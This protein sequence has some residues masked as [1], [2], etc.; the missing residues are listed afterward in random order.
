MAASPDR[1]R[2][3]RGS[4]ERPVN[5][6]LYRGT[7][8]LVGL[9]LLL[10]AFS[11]SRPGVLPQSQLP[12]AF[13]AAT[14]TDLAG[15]L[16]RDYPDRS[17]G[18]AGASNAARWVREQLGSF[19]LDVSDDAFDAKIPGRGT[20]RLHNLTAVV[21]G[22]SPAIVVMAH[23]DDDGSGAGANE[24]ASG[25]AA[26]IELARLY[27][28]PTAVG[29]GGAP[30]TT[31]HRIVF[32]STDGGAFGGIG[33]AR[34]LDRS[35]YRDSVA[36]T[37]NLD[38]VAGHAKPRLEIAGDEPR[39]PAASL[40]G[41]AAQRLR[42]QTSELPERVSA[43]GQL[44][45]L[46]FPFT[47]YEQGPFVARG[48]PAVTITTAGSR[49][50]TAF[51]DRPEALDQQTLGAI[52]T[53]SQQLL[54][55]LDQGLELAQGT[56]TYVYLGERIVRGWTIELV[57]FAVLLPFVVTAV[58]LYARCRRR[59]LALTAAARA[60]RSRLAFWLFA[61]GLFWVF[62]QLGAFPG[63][64]P[65]PPNPSSVDWPVASLAILGV[66]LLLAWLVPRDRLVP[67][68]P[69]TQEEELAG[70]TAALLGLVVV[71]LLVA[72][73]NP[74][75]L[76]FVLPSLHAWLWLPQLHGRSP[77][78][79]FLVFAAGLFGPAILLWSF[80]V[81]FGLGL[82]A[83]WYVLQLI[84]IGYVR[85]LVLPIAAVWLGA[86]AQLL[87]LAAGRYAAYP[88][89][90]ER[91]RLGPIRRLVRRLLVVTSGRR[92]TTTQRR[93]TTRRRAYGG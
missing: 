21:P 41:T 48:I 17:P 45:D 18:S 8:L 62:S 57:L 86:A 24:N 35:P 67:R 39:S 54:A 33:A 40:V 49:P 87:A 22:P 4:L 23:R 52:G 26:L 9:P 91:P 83:P 69:A 58:D 72:S 70:H 73:T 31:A 53:A 68:R 13:D 11:V 89:V 10:A 71:G 12:P 15:Q 29:G 25:T 14:A 55:S 81:R 16:A 56:T 77:A 34:F 1:R 27:A 32:L 79:R 82:D 51:L 44:V 88:D 76:I 78:V 50:P 43:G 59:R 30:V 60:L 63:G 66:L 36:A 37:L 42:E 46:A 38:A 75:A 65:R 92:S 84:S 90:S 85:P 28:T 5:A 20:A 19:G 47:L 7:W 61:V 93:G 74:F 64:E 3:R 80:A 6:R 2:P